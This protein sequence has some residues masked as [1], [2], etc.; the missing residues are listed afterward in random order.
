MRVCTW[1]INSIRARLGIVER[2]LAGERPDVLLLQET[3]AK[4]SDFPEETFQSLGY[5]TAR[6]GQPSYNGVAILSRFPLHDVRIGLRRGDDPTERRVLRARVEPA[7]GASFQVCS[8]YVPNG[9]SLDSPA[10]ELKLEFLDELRATLA[11]DGNTE[12]LIV[13]GDFNVARD[14]RDV[15]DAAAMT[16]QLHFT[17]QERRKLDE[18]LALGLYDSLRE[19][20]QDGKLFSWWDYRM[21]AFRRNRGLRIDYLFAGRSIISHLESARID[22][23]PRGWEQPSDHTPAVL[24]FRWP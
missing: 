16:G 4:D 12:Q 22:K 5:E 3:K 8:V 23:T 24:D 17:A 9:K 20:T 10:Y 18:L 15:F 2:Y 13:G 19:S 11:E 1:N 21:Q 6:A 7:S 14:E